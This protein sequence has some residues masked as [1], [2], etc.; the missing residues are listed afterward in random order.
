MK[1]GVKPIFQKV[2]LLDGS[3]ICSQ[4]FKNLKLR[5]TTMTNNSTESSSE[6]YDARMNWPPYTYK[7][8][9][10]IKPETYES[11]LE[12][13]NTENTSGRLM[14]LQPWICLLYTSPSP[15]DRS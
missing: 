7:D 1:I 11:F 12:F 10:N 2:R 14:E 13:L 3:F 8:Y 5:T 9:P 4:T 15:R 6:A